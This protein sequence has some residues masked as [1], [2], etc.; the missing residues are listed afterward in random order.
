VA[1]TSHDRS[2]W[3]TFY[4][5]AHDLASTLEP[6]IVLNHL[7]HGAAEAL[8]VKACTIR[9]L[10]PD[11]QT[12]SASASWGL[13]EGYLRKGAVDVTHSPIDRAALEGEPVWLEDVRQDP[14][15]QYPGQA[16][17]EGLVSVLCLPLKAH[18]RAIGVLRVYTT[19]VRAFHPEEVEFLEAIASLGAIS[20][21][22]ARMY[23]RLRRD[24]DDTMDV[25]WGGP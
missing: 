5:V 21:E 11:G 4:S 15:F 17:S 20:V 16:A 10:E 25:L 1:E 3:R 14:R 2:Y 7:V 23:E 12:L 8:N 9:L 19:M 22:N 6:P 18:G 13:S 24:L